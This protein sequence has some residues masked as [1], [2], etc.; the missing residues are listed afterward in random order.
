MYVSIKSYYEPIYPTI[1]IYDILNKMPYDILTEINNILHIN[2]INKNL[3]NKNL[4][5]FSKFMLN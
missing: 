3:E 4:Y 2:C 5:I 1:Q